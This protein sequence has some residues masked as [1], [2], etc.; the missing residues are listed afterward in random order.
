[1][2][3]RYNLG[4][5]V[6][7]SCIEMLE[8]RQLLSAGAVQSLPGDANLDGNVN[9][10]DLLVVAQNYNA[11]GA[12]WAQGDFNGDGSVGFD[13]LLALAQNYGRHLILQ[14]QNGIYRLTT[15]G[16]QGMALDVESFGNF[17]GTPVSLYYANHTS[18]QQWLVQ[19][20]GD[21]TYKIYAYSGQNSLQ[22]LDDNGGGTADGNRVTTWEDN[23]NSA[24]R[25]IFIPVGGGYWRI[26]PKNA[27]G[28][29]Q[30]LEMVGGNAAGGG[31]RTDIYSYWG[32]DNQVFRLD[33]PG[34]PA[35]LPSPKKGLAGWAN[36]IENIHP[37][38]LY[39]W[40]GTKPAGTPSNVEFV[41]MEWG[42][43]GN[44]NNSSV[45]W[46]NWVKSQPGVHELL[47]FNEPDSSSQAN[48]TV[49]A[50]LDGW[51]YMA[52]TGLPLGS[53]AAVH[54]DDQWMR[55][56]MAGAAQRGY[57][58]DF[59]T[60]H[61]YGGDDPS[62]FLGYVDYIHNLYN[63]PVWITE[64]APA[65]WSGHHGISAQ[66]AADF[67]RRVIP[68]LN[69]RPYVQR[70]SWF[71]AGPGDAALGQAALFNNDGSLTD[72]GRLYGRM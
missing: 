31:S 19:S 41:P 49:A 57:R 68:E 6:N 15:R 5:R 42:Y 44:A 35:I 67:M 16:Q 36:E 29:Q 21:G 52:A 26:V 2:I 39:T 30:T 61:W 48:L 13:D 4:M 8:P 54:A 46:L 62:G 71:S 64:F 17:D 33:D 43:Y 1:M 7:R 32:G 25:W 47:G 23:N 27:A 37:S 72:L 18:N 40:G 53:P 63:K 59:V 10:A 66:Q 65:D 12:S 51:K 58:V 38:W 20:Q 69:R 70:Y 11:S 3:G 60:I 34:A 9:F 14:P 50:A 24:Q 28:T 45:N 55:D 22:M 56:F